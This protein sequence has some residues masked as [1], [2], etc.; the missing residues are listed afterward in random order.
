[1]YIKYIENSAFKYMYCLTSNNKYA[2][3]LQF[4]A[5]NLLFHLSLCQEMVR[6]YCNCF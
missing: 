3:I 2:H 5:V 1:M 4:G 6:L